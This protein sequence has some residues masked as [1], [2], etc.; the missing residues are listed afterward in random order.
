MAG[1]ALANGQGALNYMEALN[2][3]GGNLYTMLGVK[4]KGNVGEFV[5]FEGSPL[6]IDRRVRAVRNAAGKVDVRA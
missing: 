1:I 4:A 2:L 6:D 5:V 3:V